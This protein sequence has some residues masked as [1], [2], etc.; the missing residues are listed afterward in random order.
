[1]T[2]GRFLVGNPAVA[3]S[4]IRLVLGGPLFLLVRGRRRRREQEAPA[5][6]AIE[7]IRSDAGGLRPAW[8][9]STRN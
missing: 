6:V 7:P 8:R 3:V 1:M 2:A 5:L 9:T 4:L